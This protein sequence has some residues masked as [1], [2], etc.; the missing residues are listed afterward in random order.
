MDVTATAL[1]GVPTKFIR[2]RAVHPQPGGVRPDHRA[3]IR[4]VYASD[5]FHQDPRAGKRSA[6]DRPQHG[7]DEPRD[8]Q[9]IDKRR[10][11]HPGWTAPLNGDLALND[12]IGQQN[13]GVHNALFD[14]NSPSQPSINTN[15]A[16]LDVAVP[17]VGPPVPGQTICNDGTHD[18]GCFRGWALFHVVSAAKLGG[19]EEGTITG[20]FLTGITRSASADDVCAA[21]RQCVRRILPRHV[22]HQTDRLDRSHPGLGEPRRGARLSRFRGH[23][24]RLRATGR[25][26]SCRTIDPHE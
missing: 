20:Y 15:L 22:R 18:I 26:P 7:V 4:A 16:G 13:N 25:S 9:C 23:R 1:T 14:S 21:S 12:Y 8:R 24:W 2:D 5:R 10:Q 19:G 11:G 17:I 3:A 6:A